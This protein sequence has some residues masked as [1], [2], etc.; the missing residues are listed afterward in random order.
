VHYR[1]LNQGY[2]PAIYDSALY[3]LDGDSGFV[4][5]ELMALNFIGG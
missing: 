2:E 4:K 3:L 1:S 5:D